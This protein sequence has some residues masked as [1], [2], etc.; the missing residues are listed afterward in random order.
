MVK[1]GRSHGDNDFPEGRRRGGGCRMLSL[2]CGSRISSYDAYEFEC[3]G[4]VR[5]QRWKKK[6]SWI[7]P[8]DA[9][10]FA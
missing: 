8:K 7:Q 3:T 10:G 2:G 5:K 9:S 1:N 6:S 4:C